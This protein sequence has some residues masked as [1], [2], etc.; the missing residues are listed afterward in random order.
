[1][2]PV[3]SGR[4]PLTEE[5]Y[6]RDYG[7][8]RDDV[9]AAM[10]TCYTHRAINHI[11]ATDENILEKMN[12]T[13]DFWRATSFSLQNTLFIVL[14]RILDSDPEVHS[15]YPVINATIA[16]PEFFN[17]SALRARKLGIPGGQWNMLF[18]DDYVSKAWEPAADDLRLMKRALAPHKRKFD[19]IY[20]PIRNQHVA[21]IALKDASLIADLYNKTQKTDID[22]I[23][24]FLHSLIAAISDLAHNAA[25]PNLTGDNYGYARRVAEITAETEKLLRQLR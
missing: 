1:M 4:P 25:R 17:R 24:L 23:L 5:E 13:S 8:I 16:H 7:I 21:H 14:A 10:V 6:W 15:I 2:V 9:N 11:G 20:K 3:P 19:A 22:E 12:R 18:L